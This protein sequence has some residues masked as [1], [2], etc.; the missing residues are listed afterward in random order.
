MTTPRRPPHRDAKTRGEAGLGGEQIEGRQAVRALLAARRRRVRDVWM[1]TGVDPAP[2]LDEIRQLADAARVPIRSVGRERIDGVA[3]TEAPQ[4]V[5]AHAEPIPPT[6]EDD[7][8]ANPSAFLVALDGLTDPR[9]LGAVLRS[10]EAAGATGVLLPKHR[11]AHVTP[12]AAKAAAGAIEYLPMALVAGIPAALERAGRAGVWCVGLDDDG[13]SDLFDLT[14]ADQPV[15]LVLGA[16]G[17]GLSRLARKR[18]DVVVR[19]PML[20]SVESLN[21]AAAATL[22]L[23]EVARRRL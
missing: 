12:A 23:F 7:L 20:G 11:S 21:V 5:L 13:D 1:A 2:V 15:V 18:C 19:I 17:R 8:Y 6:N 9:N 14:I 4:G 22:G 16:E 3:R 10:A